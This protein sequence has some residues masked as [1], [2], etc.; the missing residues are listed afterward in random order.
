[1]MRSLLNDDFEDDFEDER[2]MIEILKTENDDTLRDDD[3]RIFGRLQIM[4]F[5]I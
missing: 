2:T 3:M 4:T 5:E 1:M